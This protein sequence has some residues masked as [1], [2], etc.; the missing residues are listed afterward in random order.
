MSNVREF[1]P[2]NPASIWCARLYA[3]FVYVFIGLQLLPPTAGTANLLFWLVILYWAFIHAKIHTRP[4]FKESLWLV[5][6]LALLVLFVFRGAALWL[7][8]LVLLYWLLISLTRGNSYFLR[9]HLLTA[10]MLG[11]VL[12]LPF[13]IVDDGAQCVIHLCRAFGLTAVSATLL[14]GFGVAY[15]MA[16]LVLCGGCYV[17][18]AAGALFGFSP[19][20]PFVSANVQYMA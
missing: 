13:L 19:R 10:L 20:L 15:P 14:A 7:A 9:Y 5:V 17:Y 18:M 6:I 8:G 11:Y 1:R 16:A 12:T 3:V 4:R 2:P